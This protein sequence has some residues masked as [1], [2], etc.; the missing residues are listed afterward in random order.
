MTDTLLSYLDGYVKT[1]RQ[2]RV[3]Y[4][5]T[6]KCASTFYSTLFES[7]HWQTQTLLDI[8]WDF[9][10]VFS[11]IMDPMERRLKG[12]AEF[13]M[14]LDHRDLLEVTEFWPMVSYLDFHS[15]PYTMTYKN[16]CNKIDWIPIDHPEFKSEHLV[17]ILLRDNNISLDWSFTESHRSTD[18]KKEVYNK[19]KSLSGQCSGAVHIS[20]E[21]DIKLYNSVCRSIQFYKKTWNEI[22]WLKNCLTVEPI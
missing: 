6:L 4:I 16:F 19:I 1:Y 15:M 14:T 20:L 21:E 13:I 18:R 9:D 7:N 17:E 22:S 2:G 11:F 12:L 10:H 8:D 5:R 3:V